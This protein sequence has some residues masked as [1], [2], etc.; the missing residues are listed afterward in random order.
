MT[1]KNTDLKT[2]PLLKETITLVT[3]VFELKNRI[4]LSPK[5]GKEKNFVFLKAPTWV[6]VLALTPSNQVILVRQFRHGSREFS[7]ELPGGVSE[8]FQNPLE[9]A[10]RELMEETGYSSSDISLLLD[11]KPNPAIFDNHIQT[12]LAKDAIKTGNTCFDENE[13]LENILVPRDQ[14]KNMILNGQIDH[15]LMVAA[16]GFYLASQP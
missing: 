13:D 10:K 3:P 14:L 4:C 12:F 8:P 15:A 2:W 1:E 16:I 5:D 9:T 7:L 6:N 11:V